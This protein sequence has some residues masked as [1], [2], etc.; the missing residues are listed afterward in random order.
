M[1]N[2]SP[3]KNNMTNIVMCTLTNSTHV[4]QLIK[5]IFNFYLKKQIILKIPNFH[6]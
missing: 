1:A 4:C 5:Y 3:K 6:S 2:V